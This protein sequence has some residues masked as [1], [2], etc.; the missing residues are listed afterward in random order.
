MLF[1]S[2]FQSW[3]ILS[4]SVKRCCP[5]LVS[6]ICRSD[7]RTTLHYPHQAQEWVHFDIDTFWKSL[8]DKI[9]PLLLFSSI[10]VKK[11]QKTIYIDA[12]IPIRF[13]KGWPCSLRNNI[14]LEMLSSLKIEFLWSWSLYSC[15]CDGSKARRIC[16]HQHSNIPSQ[17]HLT[18]QT[19]II[20][21]DGHFFIAVTVYNE[22]E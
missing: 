10:K 11:C 16:K 20:K 14:D 5:T 19:I 1:S 17:S 18:Q 8:Q 21:E 12:I 22:A 15:W 3:S 13:Q 9:L 2:C 7:P 4:P 6:T